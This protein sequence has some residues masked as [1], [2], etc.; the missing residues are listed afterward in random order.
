MFPS[1]LHCG[2][3]HCGEG[4]QNIH[5]LVPGG[6]TPEKFLLPSARSRFNIIL[7]VLL[8]SQVTESEKQERHVVA[9]VGEF[10]VI[11]NFRQVKNNDHVCYKGQ[12]GLKSCYCYKIVPKDVSIVDSK[13]MLVVICVN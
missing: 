4:G 8:Q 11:W 7:H 3:L 12:N 5:G 9:T 6:V 1:E 10:S 2:E 13:F